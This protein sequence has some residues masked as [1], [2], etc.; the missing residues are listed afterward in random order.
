MRGIHVQHASWGSW[1]RG[2]VTRWNRTELK[3]RSSFCID[4]IRS[5]L[6]E[7]RGGREREREGGGGRGQT[8][9][10]EETQRDRQTD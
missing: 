6:Q 1:C 9:T 10:D 4:R 3:W 7:G 8:S 2:T 5:L